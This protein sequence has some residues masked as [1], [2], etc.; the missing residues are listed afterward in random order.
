MS[1]KNISIPELNLSLSWQN[2][3]E[4]IKKL[5]NFDKYMTFFWLL[6]PF[7]YLIERDPADLWLTLICI[8]FLI[9]CF[10]KKHW[11]WAFQLWF[12]CALALWIFGLFASI[13]GPDPIFT[14]Q[15]GFVWIRFPLYAA[16]AQAW[17]ARDRDIRIIMLLSITLGMIMMSIILISETIIEP[18]TRL[19]WPYGDKIPGTYLAKFCLPVFCVLVA[20]AVSQKNKL[21]FFSGIIALLSIVVSILTGE[22]TNFLIRACGGMLAGLVYKPRF[23]FYA[24]LIIFETIAVFAIIF[25]CMYHL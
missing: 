13:T 8:I 15:Q 14:F 23:I 3:W 18:K 2:G 16:A 22:R 20:I 25:K 10:I 9:R 11:S 21:G 6:G 12:K 17:L 19:T 4:K 1:L 5:N 24:I 7:I